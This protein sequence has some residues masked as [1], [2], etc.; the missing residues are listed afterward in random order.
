MLEPDEGPKYSYT[1]HLNPIAAQDVAVLKEK[2]E[3]YG[4]SWLEYGGFSAFFATVRKWDRIR[5]QLKRV[6]WNVFEAYAAD[7]RQEGFMDD[8]RDL[9]RYLMLWEAR[10]IE[11]G[12]VPE[13]QMYLHFGEQMVVAEGSEVKALLDDARQILLSAGLDAWARKDAPELQDSIQHWCARHDEI[14]K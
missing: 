9:R 13:E 4:A 2:D 5:V 3:N 1:K 8:V 14:A 11:L 7:K 12:L 6:G 10:A